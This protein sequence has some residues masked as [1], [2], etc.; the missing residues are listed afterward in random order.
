MIH[1]EG[2]IRPT[3]IDEN[4]EKSPQETPRP[5]VVAVV[6]HVDHG[7]TT[8]LDKLR[9][10]GIEVA[11]HEAGRITQTISAFSVAM[12]KAIVGDDD[13]KPSTVT[14]IDTPGHGAF[15]TL[16]ERVG[17]VTDVAILVVSARDGFQEQTFKS[18][19]LLAEEEVQA[20]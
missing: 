19:E 3:R 7:K 17:Q 13:T 11:S 5:P 15:K 4:R 2:D 20:L 6:G 10:D 18:I 9:G 16:R 14:F 12:D 1:E 8:L